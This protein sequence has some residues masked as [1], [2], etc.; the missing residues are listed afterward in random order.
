M[1]KEAV[2]LQPSQGR[3]E[4]REGHLGSPLA[5]EHPLQNRIVAMIQPLSSVRHL[6]AGLVLHCLGGYRLTNANPQAP[7]RR[8]R[9]LDQLRWGWRS[10]R[11]GLA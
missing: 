5:A 2:A 9:W 7:F 6:E 11:A 8:G 4:L 10:P 3:F 1:I